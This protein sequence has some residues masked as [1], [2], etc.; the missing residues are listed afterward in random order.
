[1]HIKQNLVATSKYSLKCPYSMN[2]QYITVHNTYND[3]PAANEI[4]YMIG[5]SNSTSFHVAVD[6]KEAIQGISFNR[7]AW[8]CGDGNGPGNRK[9]ISIE[10]CYSKSGGNR[11]YKAEENA[12]VVVAKLMKQY[13]IP[14]SNVRTHQHWNNKYCPHRILAEGRW[15]TFIEKVKKAYNGGG[16]QVNNQQ[17][18]YR[19]N[20]GDF[21]SIEWTAAALTKVKET[22]PGYGIWTQCIEGGYHRI[23]VGDF[24][25]KQW[26]DETMEKLKPLDYGMWIQSL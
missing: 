25:S 22:L 19:I 23:I 24:N 21:D 2:P 18:S 3:A 6:D 14:I 20:I 8:A 11:Y 1:M 7:N 26:A 5:N 15:N 16:N 9:S 17:P 13:G 4:K 12:A 10:I